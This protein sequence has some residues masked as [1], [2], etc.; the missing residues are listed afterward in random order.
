MHVGDQY[1]VIRPFFGNTIAYR[2]HDHA[3]CGDHGS[4][5]HG[6][7]HGDDHHDPHDLFHSQSSQFWKDK[8]V[9]H[10]QYKPE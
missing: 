8:T 2:V 3:H 9:G 5:D 1:Q 10:Q 4:H 6:H 7:G